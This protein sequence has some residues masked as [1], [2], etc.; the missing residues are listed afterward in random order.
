M[1]VNHEWDE[2][3]LAKSMEAA[4]QEY[5]RACYGDC[6]LPPAQV[7][8]T[9]QAFMSGIHWLNSRESYDPADVESGLRAILGK[10]NPFINQD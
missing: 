6:E 4:F 2:E 9:K 5:R 3:D 8:E 10:H 1:T 7:R